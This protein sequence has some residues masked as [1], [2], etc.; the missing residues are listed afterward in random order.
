MAV[1]HKHVNK[2][3]RGKY[4][5]AIDLLPMQGR[6]LESLAIKIDWSR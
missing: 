2:R 5:D 4:V 1:E 6:E 3:R